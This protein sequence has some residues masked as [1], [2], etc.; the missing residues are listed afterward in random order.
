[1]RRGGRRW[2]L[3]ETNPNRAT[4]QERDMT[5]P[6]GRGFDA[7]KA[8]ARN[9]TLYNAADVKTRA[10]QAK[11]DGVDREDWLRG[12]HQA[13]LMHAD[14]AGAVDLSEW[15]S[16][17]VQEHAAHWPTEPITPEAIETVLGGMLRAIKASDDD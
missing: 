7:A 3:V 14:E 15:A 17:A 10:E 11:A 12:I 9:M 5:T 1:M 2:S 13:A 8:E 4:A 16:R 6:A